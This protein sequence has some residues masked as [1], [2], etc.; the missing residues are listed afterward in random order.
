MVCI[1]RGLAHKIGWLLKTNQV[2]LLGEEFGTHLV[3]ANDGKVL[4]GCV[5]LCN[6]AILHDSYAKHNHSYDLVLGAYAW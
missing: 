5:G 4:R 1:L 6:K 3:A 2:V